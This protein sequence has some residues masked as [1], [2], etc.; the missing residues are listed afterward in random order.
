MSIP[1]FDGHSDTLT[2]IARVANTP[3]QRSFFERSAL[4]HIDLPRAKEGQLAGGFF[5]IFCPNAPSDAWPPEESTWPKHEG[6]YCKPLPV[7]I[8]QPRAK[9]FVDAMIDQLNSWE[10]SSDGEVV[11]VRTL[12]EWKSALEK[13]QLSAILHFEGAEAILPD[14]SNFQEYYDLGLRSLGPVWSRPNV[15]AHGVPFGFPLSPD[16]GAG[17]TERGFALLSACNE[18]GVLFDV[19]HLNEKGFWDVE[20]HSSHPIV[21]THS[22]A[23]SLCKHSRNLTDKQ[24]DAL[25]ASNGLVGVNYCTS[26]LREDGLEGV[27]TSLSEIVRHARYIANRIG[28]QHVALGSDFDGA[29]MPHDLKDVAA[30]PQLLEAL[31]KAGF[32][33]NE[34]EMIAYKNWERV[35]ESTWK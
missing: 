26:F 35:L 21:A 20:K 3:S 33:Y 1:V 23:W 17:L 16:T 8:Q 13:K 28:V 22:A 24:L 19:S 34:V 14:L 6:G 4:G 9:L 10:S 27:S 2:Q 11:L 15:F 31:Q 18:K 7:P 30:L 5:A 12:S 32:H 29:T 25:A